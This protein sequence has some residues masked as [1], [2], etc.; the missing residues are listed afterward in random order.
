MNTDTTLVPLEITAVHTYQTTGH[1]TPKDHKFNFITLRILFLVWECSCLLTDMADDERDFKKKA[2]R[3]AGRVAEG[4]TAT[5]HMPRQYGLATGN[6]LSKSTRAGIVDKAA[7]KCL[8]RLDNAHKG[9]TTPHIN[10]NPKLTGV[11]DPHIPIPGSLVKGGEMATKALNAVGKAALVAGVVVDTYRVGEALYSDCTKTRKK[12]PGKRTAKA[13]A[14]VAGGWAGGCA[15]AAAG[16]ST[17]AYI[18]GAI[19]ALFGGVGAV[20]GAAIGSLIGAVAGGVGGGVGASCAAEAL[21]EELVSDPEEDENEEN[22]A[23]CT[24]L[25]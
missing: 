2:V 23:V 11:K 9:V 25:S 7:G 22:S 18:G 24:S 15:G 12:R 21:V 8:L 6:Y 3:N 16:S 20:P 19:G 1:Y 17:G 4:V 5:R 10:I 14:S 13:A